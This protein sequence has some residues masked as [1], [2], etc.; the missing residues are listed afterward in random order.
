MSKMQ[1]KNE[2]QRLQ[3]LLQK[4][5]WVASRLENISARYARNLLKKIAVFWKI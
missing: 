3:H 4:K 2:P 5:G 1:H